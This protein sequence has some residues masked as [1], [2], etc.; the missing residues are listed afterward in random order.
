VQ[1]G[2]DINYMQWS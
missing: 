1:I 2:F